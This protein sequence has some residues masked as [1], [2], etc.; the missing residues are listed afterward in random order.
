MHVVVWLPQASGKASTRTF[1]L[2]CQLILR[3]NWSFVKNG[4]CF[5]C[6][7][8]GLNLP[9]I[10]LF[11]QDLPLFLCRVRMFRGRPLHPTSRLAEVDSRWLAVFWNT[12]DPF[13]SG[14]ACRNATPLWLFSIGSNLR[15]IVGFA[16]MSRP[17]TSADRP[18]TSA[19]QPFTSASWP[20]TSATRPFPSAGWCLLF[21]I[22]RSQLR[23]A[24]IL[25]VVFEKNAEL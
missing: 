5:V 25:L 12:S 23:P 4:C 14:S 2:S 20:L 3:F 15:A 24:T 8:C 22:K 1:R 6:R 9:V 10:P 13:L 11:I 16:Q 19:G 21:K 18:F 17:F 7:T